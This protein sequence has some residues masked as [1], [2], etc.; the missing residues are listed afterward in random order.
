MKKKIMFT[1]YS[2]DIGGIETALV[3][4]LNELIKKYDITLVLEKKQGIFLNELNN[5][6]RVVE[7]NPNQNRNV[8]LRKTINFLKRINFIIK[9][10]NKFYFAASFATYSK[11]GSF[12]ARTASKN[13]ALWCHA[14]YSK[15]FNTKNEMQDF[16]K[17]ISHEK[18]RKIV[19]V[20]NEGAEDFINL[21]PEKKENII[22]CNNLIN[23]KKILDLANE[24]IEFENV[25]FKTF[26]NVG[27]QEEK[28]KKLSKLIEACKILAEEK[29][30][31]RVLMVGDGPDSNKYKEMVKENGLEEYIL[32]LGK[33]KNPYP[34]FKISDSVILTSEYEG[35]PVVY[36]E[37]MVLETPI[38]TTNVSDSKQ[39][40]EG[41]F[42]N[43]I[44]K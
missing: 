4:L 21:F 8:L 40:I 18:F 42:R 32:F 24:K 10:K 31:F 39:D 6:I 36:V 7:Y 26:L 23:S 27:R 44:K 11:M 15:I 34:Y 30:K 12:C 19:F 20:S 1:A 16:F 41:K 13:S 9:Y 2:L 38:L 29:Y 17:F 28:Q 33:K 3:N 14:K 37:A 5:E 43:S 35:Y 22:V 25:N